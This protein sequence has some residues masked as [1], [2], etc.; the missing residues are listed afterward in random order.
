MHS[1]SFELNLWIHRIHNLRT[2]GCQNHLA[3]QLL[4]PTKIPKQNL[5]YQ[6]N[7]AFKSA[8][9]RILDA[10]ERSINY[11]ILDVYRYNTDY[12]ILDIHRYNINCGI[13]NA[14]RYNDFSKILN[15]LKIQAEEILDA[16][17]LEYSTKILDASGINATEIL[18]ALKHILTKILN[19]PKIN[20]TE[21]LDALKHTSTKIL[22]APRINATKILD[23]VGLYISK[24]ADNSLCAL[25]STP[26]SKSCACKHMVSHLKS[27]VRSGYLV[28]RSDP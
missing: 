3:T 10:R 13:L 18:D 6:Y 20:A 21:I 28:C 7:N 26:D 27:G 12:K 2:R 24:S 23:A 19:A 14:H 5:A 17:L 9:I 1:S 8:S 4:Y 25:S 15:A 22:N 11:G 16:A